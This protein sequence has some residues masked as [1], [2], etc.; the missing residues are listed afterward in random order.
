MTPVNQVVFR[1][2]ANEFSIRFQKLASAYDIRAQNNLG[3][4]FNLQGPPR[5]SAVLMGF[6][7][8]IGLYIHTSETVQSY[9]A[10]LA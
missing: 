1:N 5:R 3:F 2:K 6:T 7:I 9:R 8:I 4:N 10:D